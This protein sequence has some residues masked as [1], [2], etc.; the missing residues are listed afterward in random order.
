MF[1][2]TRSS[3]KARIEVA[4]PESSCRR[5]RKPGLRSASA[6]TGASAATNSAS[7]GESSGRRGIATLSCAICQSAVIRFQ[8]I[9][10]ILR[11]TGQSLHRFAA[12]IPFKD[13]LPASRFPLITVLLIAVNIGVFVWQVEFP[14]DHDLERAGLSGGVGQASSSVPLR[15]ASPTRAT[16]RAR[17]P[18]ARSAAAPTPAGCRSTRTDWWVTVLASMAVAGTVLQLGLNMLLPWIFGQSVEDRL[19]RPRLLLFYL[20]AGIAAAYITRL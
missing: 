11:S 12:L 14:I 8:P 20:C 13:N 15:R 10:A 3:S 2:I 4:S 5:Q 16:A 1:T 9:R 7:A 19:G 18:A 6:F 17:S